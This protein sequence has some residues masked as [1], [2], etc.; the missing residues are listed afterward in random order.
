M[1]EQGQEGMYI[2]GTKVTVSNVHHTL[3]QILMT[4][5]LKISSHAEYILKVALV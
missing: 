1:V 4:C 2:F 5:Q 3:L